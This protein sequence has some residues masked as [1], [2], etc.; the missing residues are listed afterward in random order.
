MRDTIVYLTNLN[1]EEMEIRM[2]EKL[3]EQGVYDKTL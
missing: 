2:L 3:E 1:A